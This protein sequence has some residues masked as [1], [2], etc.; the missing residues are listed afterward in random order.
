MLERIV[1]RLTPTER[2]ALTALVSACGLGV[3][4][5]AFGWDR[6]LLED[7][8]R[9][10]H[11]PA[12]T[13]SE[14]AARLAPGDLR[15]EL[16]ALGRALAAERRRAAAGPAPVDP[17]AAGRADWD[18]LPGI[19]PR[20]AATILQHRAEH[21]PFRSADDL[22]AV[23]G[24]GPKTLERL[25]PWLRWPAVRPPGRGGSPGDPAG[26]PDLNRVDAR[27]LASL[28]GIGPKLA[29]RLVEER[30]RRGGFRTWSQVL[31]IRGIGPSKVRALQNATRLNAGA[32]AD[33]GAPRPDS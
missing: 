26:T 28:P 12:P 25:R 2:G 16:Y 5:G 13:A 19:G 17:N 20:T 10:L 18:R 14:L 9:R 7:A 23:K 24:I 33:S 8:E 6:A 27:F 30:G 1:E 32:G 15:V 3:A 21:G 31:D 4:A 11:P 22:L 29:T